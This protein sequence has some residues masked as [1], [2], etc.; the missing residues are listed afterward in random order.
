[1]SRVS[2]MAPDGRRQFG[3]FIQWSN[4]YALVRR[5]PSVFRIHKSD[6]TFEGR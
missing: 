5:G 4:D 2:W 1:M 3:R 6:I